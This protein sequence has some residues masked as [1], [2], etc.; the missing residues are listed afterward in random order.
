LATFLGAELR[1]AL[2]V[3]S[4]T[5]T[6][7]FWRFLSASSCM[8]G[9]LV[10]SNRPLNLTASDEIDLVELFRSLWAQKWPILACTA[11]ITAC[12]AAFA[13]LST[14]IYR[15]QAGVLPPRL[16][17]IADYNLGRSEA[18][19]AEFKVQDVYAVFK[20][21][22]LSD[23]LKRKLFLEAYLPSLSERQ[24]EEARDKLWERFN[25][26]LS[27][28]AVDVKNNP[29]FYQ[30]AV[31]HEDPQTAAEWANRYVAMAA[32]KT[33][34]EM[35]SNLLTEIGTKAQSIER[36]IEVVRRIAKKNRED[37]IIRL[38]EALVVAETVGIDAP[39][40]TAGKTSSDGE[41]AEFM[42]GNL[43][44]MR[45]ARAVRAEL[46]VLEK[47]KNDA[48]FI[49]GLRDLEKQLEFLKRVDVNP[50]NVSV[51]TLDSVAEVPETPINPKKTLI[52]ALGL[53]VGGML[54]IFVAL[55]RTMLVKRSIKVA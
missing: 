27:V 28:K 31:Q 10:N 34:L 55:I 2:P 53:V 16:S 14:P 25:S 51:F 35:Q 21:N 8:A 17:D 19:L 22:L 30:I 29:D 1:D 9:V 13:F 5:I 6:I 48:P 12:A 15:A 23:A 38:R 40:V 39:Q 32:V 49:P 33:E 36:Q 41:L 4:S 42:D 26:E 47:R 44:Y 54:G 3:A 11:L 45:G 52:L 18:A 20:R 24:A 46:A 7:V 50:D 43:M 37:R